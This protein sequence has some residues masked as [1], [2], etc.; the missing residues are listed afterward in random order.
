MSDS[1]CLICSFFFYMKQATQDDP[2][3]LFRHVG[4]FRGV[5]LFSSYT[6][7]LKIEMHGITRLLA[8]G[9]VMENPDPEGAGLWIVDRDSSVRI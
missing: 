5:R 4:F 3:T 9:S 6:S 2:S 1:E 7:D 8:K